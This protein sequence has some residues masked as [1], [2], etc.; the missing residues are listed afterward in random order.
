MMLHFRINDLVLPG[1]LSA[2]SKYIEVI[3]DVA[4]FYGVSINLKVETSNKQDLEN[5]LNYLIAQIAN[6]VD[7][8]AK[9]D[10]E[11]R[12]HYSFT[13]KIKAIIQVGINKNKS[14]VLIEP[15]RDADFVQTYIDGLIKQIVEKTEKSYSVI[16]DKIKTTYLKYNPR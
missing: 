4:N 10:D 7:E 12:K 5:Y 1:S 13:D 3:N 6:S 11:I 2:L 8:K 9:I 15:N 16:L 14:V